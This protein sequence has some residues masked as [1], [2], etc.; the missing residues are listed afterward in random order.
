MDSN[1][2]TLDE[3]VSSPDR[4]IRAWNTLSHWA[5]GGETEGSSTTNICMKVTAAD[6]LTDEILQKFWLVV[7]VPG[8]APDLETEEKQAVEHFLD[9]TYRGEDGRYI[10]QLP[11]KKSPPALGEPRSLAPNSTSFE[12]EKTSPRRILMVMVAEAN[13]PR[14]SNVLATAEA[15]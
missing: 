10:V 7:E 15:T 3:S 13:Q 12:S 4:S 11:R 9:T 14:T 1:K 2:C 6:G 5:I 8:D